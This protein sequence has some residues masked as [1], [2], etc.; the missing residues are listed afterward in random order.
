[1]S[2]RKH[3]NINLWVNTDMSRLDQD[4]HVIPMESVFQRFHSNQHFGLSSPFVHDAQLNYGTNQITPPRSQNYFWL[5]FQQL[6]MG[7]N[8]ILWLGGILA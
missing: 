6:F 2:K 8:L 4:V 1:M 3:S 5:L 7:F